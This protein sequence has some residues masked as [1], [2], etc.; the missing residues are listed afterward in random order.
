M[1][2]RN[3]PL[4]IFLSWEFW[5]WLSIDLEIMRLGSHYN[6]QLLSDNNCCCFLKWWTSFGCTAVLGKSYWEMAY[7]K[8]GWW[9]MG[10]NSPFITVMN[11]FCLPYVPLTCCYHFAIS[12]SG[13]KRRHVALSLYIYSLRKIWVLKEF[14]EYKFEAQIFIFT[15]K[16]TFSYKP[17]W[18]HN[19]I[20]YRAHI[21]FELALGCKWDIE[22]IR[23]YHSDGN[24]LFL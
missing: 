11:F 5:N 17:V 6:S 22:L 18:S 20:Y 1:N 3:V 16:Q 9:V 10:K 13:L 24:N 12:T 4:S 14:V 7:E 23:I 21:K 15:L 19:T 8:C 2:Y